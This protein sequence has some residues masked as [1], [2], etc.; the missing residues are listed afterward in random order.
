M[1]KIVMSKDISEMLDTLIELYDF[2]KNTLS[3]YL[4]ISVE[5]I[6]AIAQGNVDCLP[7]DF[8]FR[9]QI[10]AKVGF[11]YFGPIENEDLRLSAFLEILISY[12]DLSKKTIAKMAG[13]ET[14]DIAKMLSNP[15]QKIETETKYKIAIAVMALRCFLKDCEPPIG[16]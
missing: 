5:E 4:G 9:N 11:L 12:H 7:E 3:K 14:S 8:A 6:E 15:P 16:S 13:V 2:N 1:K 10:I